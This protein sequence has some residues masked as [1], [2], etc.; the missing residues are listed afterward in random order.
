M[1]EWHSTADAVCTLRFLPPSSSSCGDVSCCISSP[2]ANS[3]WPAGVGGV[4]PIPCRRQNP[5][6]AAYDNAAPPATNSSWTRTRFPWHWAKSSR[7]CCRYGSAFSAR[8]TSGTVVEF[9]RR[10]WRTATREIP[11]TRVISRLL[12]P[13]ACSSRI[14]VRC[15][16]LNMWFF[17][18]LDF[19]AH[20][21]KLFL[22][23]IDLKP[24]RFA[25]L[26]IQFPGCGP[27]QPALCAVHDRGHHL[28]IAQQFGA[29]PGWGFL[30]RLPLRFE[31]QSGIVQNAF[32]NRG[33]ALPPGGI[34]LA[35]FPR[36]A[37]MLRENRRHPPAILH[38]LAGCRHEEL[39]GHLRR[40]LALAHLL[41]NRLR[42]KLHQRQP[43][44]YPAHAAVEPARQ[45]LQPVAETLLQLR[46]QPAHLQ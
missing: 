27:R 24:R 8:C 7:I 14:A 35:R 9:D 15:A 34:Q 6:N 42:Q 31:K 36:I 39:H 4:Y 11:S 30:L 41:L 33:R 23:A 38:A 40:D 12:T 16:W 3:Y 20:A 44:R 5:V 17:L 46:Q 29:C 21:A 45:L 19:F 26:E 43:L 1:R 22:N 37:A 25:L 13:L 18:R 32:A 2:G 28:Q 10:T